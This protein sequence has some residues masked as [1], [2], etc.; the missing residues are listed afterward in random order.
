MLITLKDNWLSIAT[1]VWEPPREISDKLTTSNITLDSLTALQNKY[2]EHV[3]ILFDSSTRDGD[4]AK[5]RNYFDNGLLDVD[6]SL[7][8]FISRT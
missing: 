6:E 4:L 5:V 2:G 1:D 7:G 8:M 3:H